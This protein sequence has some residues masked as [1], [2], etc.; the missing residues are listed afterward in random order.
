MKTFSLVCF[1]LLACGVAY[2]APPLA[3]GGITPGMSEA[4]VIARLGKPDRIERGSGF[5]PRTLVYRGLRIDLD[6]DR[7]VAGARSSRPSICLGNGLCPGAKASAA[8]AKLP[9]LRTGS[10]TLSTGEG[11]WVEVPIA[12]GRVNAVAFVCQP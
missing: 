6:E 9:E 5:L 12:R 2:A 3:V 8:Y 10:Q 11:C 4:A 1:L 7:T